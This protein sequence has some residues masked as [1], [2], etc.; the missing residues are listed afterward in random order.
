MDTQVILGNYNS[1]WLRFPIVTDST[2]VTLGY[3]A[4]TYIVSVVY[5]IRLCTAYK[6]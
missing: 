3:M 2:L 1:I 6:T 4:H 5:N